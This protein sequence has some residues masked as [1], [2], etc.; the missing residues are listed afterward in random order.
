MPVTRLL[1]GRMGG[2]ELRDEGGDESTIRSAELDALRE[3]IIEPGEQRGS[4]EE[5]ALAVPR[6]GGIGGSLGERGVWL[7][8]VGEWR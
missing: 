4:V 1:A 6:D 3:Q 7:F 8:V 2:V 5:L